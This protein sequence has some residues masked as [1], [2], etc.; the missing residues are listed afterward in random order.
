MT[1]PIRITRLVD[2]A[3]TIDR[4]I[5]S[6][7]A[8]LKEIKAQIVA[9]AEED[10]SAH[11]EGQGGGTVHISE[12]SDG[13]IARVS[14]PVP[15]LASSL[16]PEKKTFAKIKELAGRAFNELFKPVISYD[17]VDGFRDRASELLEPRD[18][19]ALI[20]ACTSQ[21]KPRVS[22]ETSDTTA[23]A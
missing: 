9:F 1:T 18:A 22:F 11:M 16:D 14:F 10:G 13:S 21:S 6:K 20:K 19:K 2:E 23:A 8:R 3:I 15:K 4:E 5:E 12:G 17:L 7:E